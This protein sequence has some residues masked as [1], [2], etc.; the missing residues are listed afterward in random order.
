MSIFLA[1]VVASY[2]C[3]DATSS[4]TEVLGATAGDAAD[5]TSAVD[6]LGT[7]GG[8]ALQKVAS[9]GYTNPFSQGAECKE[10]SGADWTL[11][12]AIVDCETV[13][14]GT[15]GTFAEDTACSYPSELG[16]CVIGEVETNGYVIVSEGSNPND[17]PLAKAGCEQFG[18]GT[19]SPGTLCLEGTDGA[20]G[21]SDS[22]GTDSL[23]GIDGGYP[24]VFVEGFTECKAPVE[25]DPPGAGRD[26]T[27][28][29]QNMIGGC[30]E[31]GYKFIDY[32]SCDVVYTQRPY[33]PYP[34]PPPGVE[35]DARLDDE[36]YMS[37]LAWV[38]EQVESCG[39]VCCHSKD[40]APDG[41]SAWYTDAGPLWIDTVTDTGVALFTGIADSAAL[42]AYLAS[43]NNGFDRL[44]T[45]LPTTDIPRMQAFW[46]MEL[47]RRGLDVDWA[48]A[49]PPFGGFLLDQM[50]YVPEPCSAGVGIE[51][52]G[53]VRWGT[54]KVRY[55]YILEVGSKMPG[56]PP[57]L[58]IPEGTIWMLGVNH[59]QPPFGE[60]Y[61]YG[62]APDGVRQR[63]PGTGEPPALVSGESYVLVGLLDV[64]VPITR[65]VFTAP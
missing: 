25:G 29:T 34:A 9:C 16:R 50:N 14:P 35:G 61:T 45:G 40:I 64:A 15:A 49:V 56:A 46:I 65:C 38:T 59:M 21:S 32:A 24:G 17:C 2:G 62:E 63:V 39:C 13:F 31:P 53:T 6:G 51:D 26:G 12:A 43:D 27:V 44:T 37:E 20:D 36:S 58:D 52:D 47:E 42:G 28:C 3:S 1:S 23:D 41:P 7:A 11:E 19:F 18:G 48:A 22:D 55:A 30:T 33:Y 5:T 57:N 10:Y 60:G 8:T 54:S 4:P